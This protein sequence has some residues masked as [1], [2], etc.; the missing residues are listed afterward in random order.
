MPGSEVQYQIVSTEENFGQN[1]VFVEESSTSGDTT[2]TYMIPMVGRGSERI[3]IIQNPN[4]ET[5]S[6]VRL[7]EL[8]S[9]HTTLHNQSVV[10]MT[11]PE[12]QIQTTTHK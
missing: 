10:T 2:E 3:D 9:P 6:K 1:V 12:P 11:M 8:S 7:D 4:F 5:N